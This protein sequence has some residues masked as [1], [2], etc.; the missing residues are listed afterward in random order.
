MA[1]RYFQPIF[2]RMS[3]D[4]SLRRA[5]Q[6]SARIYAVRERALRR[7]DWQAIQ[8]SLEVATRALRSPGFWRYME[9]VRRASEVA[10]RRIGA[11]GSAASQRIAARR[12][13]ESLADLE[14]AAPAPE[15]L[16]GDF[17]AAQP[18]RVWLADTSPTYRRGKAS[19]TP[20]LH[21]GRPFEKDR[22]VVDELTPT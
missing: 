15:L 13:S 20:G 3:R 10:E 5:F 21:P 11:D 16:R 19:S 6:D 4:E 12:S 14:R 9:S 22:R 17:V 1:Q 7:I 18:N 2:E 8:R